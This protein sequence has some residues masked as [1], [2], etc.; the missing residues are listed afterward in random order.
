M[1]DLFSGCG[2]LSLGFQAAGFDIVSGLDIDQSAISTASYNLSW[3]FGSDASY[4]CCDIRD[5]SNDELT[6]FNAQSPLVVIGGPP[7]QAYSLIGRAKL[8]S[9]GEQ[10]EHTRDERGYL[11]EDF[12]RVVSDLMPDAVVMEN[13]PESVDYGGLNV[14]EHVSSMLASIGYQTRWTILNAADYGVPQARE[15]VF[16]VAVRGTRPL[17]VSFPNPTHASPVDELTQ[18]DRRMKRFEGLDYFVHPPR[19]D[20]KL[21]HWITVE[22]AFSD[23]PSLFPTSSSIY[24][25]YKPSVRLPYKTQAQNDFQRLM[26]SWY[27]K[28]LTAVTGNSFRRTLRDFPIFERMTEGDDFTDASL[29]ADQILAEAVRA[30][31][32]DPVE[33]KAEYDRLR[34][35]IVPPYDRTK[36]LSKWK[37]L[38]RSR[39]SHTVTA[40]LG[41]DTYSHIHPWEPRGISVRE[42]AR[43]QSF[44]DE[45]LFQGT[46]SEAFRQIGNAVPPLLAKAVASEV[47]KMI[48][49][50]DKGVALDERTG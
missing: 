6:N 10:R 41:V 44:P 17:N 34:R 16:V 39:P 43:L 24:R 3:R 38:T 11:F 47:R 8:R 5:I 45:F 14:P 50:A 13:V 22:E 23:L 9:L 15:R 40:H 30:Q 32:L 12:V 18:L 36:F 20:D 33:H 4:L 35:R 27:G 26:R 49:Q 2:G 25:L 28:G 29:I 7:C 42:A 1:I 46:M 37:K 19:S 48:L 31:A 21:E